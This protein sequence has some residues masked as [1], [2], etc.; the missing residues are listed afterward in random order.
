VIDPI[1]RI[2][3]RLDPHLTATAARATIARLDRSLSRALRDASP[4]QQWRARHQLQVARLVRD[5]GG[6]ELAPCCLAWG[7]A[8]PGG[9]VTVVSGPR[10]GSRAWPP[11]PSL[12]ECPEDLCGRLQGELPC[13]SQAGD[14]WMEW[15][16][17]QVEMRGTAAGLQS[18]TGLR[19]FELAD[20]LTVLAHGYLSRRDV[21]YLN[22]LLRLG[23]RLLRSQ[24]L[25]KGDLSLQ[26]ALLAACVVREVC[27]GELR[28][29]EE[30]CAV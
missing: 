25:L 17:R 21:R 4:P 11:S 18:R 26:A 15:L 2:C 24:R 10:Q 23:D 8:V 16:L 6:A 3:Q 12:A 5:A 27:L 7:E 1:E 20:A 28:E 14:A 22:A 13:L 29:V 30:P 19:R 9:N